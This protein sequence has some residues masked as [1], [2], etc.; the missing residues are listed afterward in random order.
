MT[1]MLKIF[2]ATDL[3]G[4]E[5]CFKKFLNAWKFYDADVL[6]LGGDVTG[7]V[8]VPVIQ[9]RDGSYSCNFEGHKLVTKNDKELEKIKDKIRNT[10]AYMHIFNKSEFQEISDNH[11]KMNQILILEMLNTLENWI[12]TADKKLK[13]AGINCY[14]IPGNDD[15]YDID[16]ILKKGKRM[17]NVDKKVVKLKEGYEILGLGYSNNTPW[18]TFREFDE[19]QI[20]ND[21]DKL[22]RKVKDLNSCIFNIHVPPANTKLDEAEHIDEGR[23]TIF[24][25]GQT[26]LVG[27]VAVKNAIEKYQPMLSLHGHIHEAKAFTKIGRTLCINPSSEYSSGILNGVLCVL[28][29]NKIKSFQFTSG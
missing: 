29:G 16:R 18:D 5:I 17:I 22:V 4:S 24:K 12:E 10:G 23:R 21:I 15:V 20:K 7:K 27:S 6:I 19:K 11:T 13:E 14:L 2:F 28:E 26:K 8:L 3:H 25:I 1:N 9:N